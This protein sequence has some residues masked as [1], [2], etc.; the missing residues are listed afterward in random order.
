MTANL[1]ISSLYFNSYNHA[2]ITTYIQELIMRI[3]TLCIIS[4]ILLSGCQKPTESINEQAKQKNV[5][6]NVSQDSCQNLD[7]AM[8]KMNENSTI[9]TLDKI[10]AQLKQC[11]SKVKSPQQLKW[12]NASTKMYHRFLK[13]DTDE[14]SSTAF[15]DYTYSILE[16]KDNNLDQSISTALQGDPE[17]FKKLGKRDQYLLEHQG[18]AYIE[19]QYIGEGI[20]EYRR[21]P[22]Y[23]LDIF[24]RALPKDQ[25]V[26][27]HRMAK[28]NQEP[29]YNDSA[30]AV[31][32]AELVERALF[33]E[34][35]LKQYPNATFKVDA[36]NLFNEYRYLIFFGSDNTPVSDLYF[37][38]EWIDEEALIEIQ[39]L[40]KKQDTT[41]QI[42]AQKFL[43]F[44]QFSTDEHNQVMGTNDSPH[45]LLQQFL[46]L[47]NIWATDNKKDCHRDAICTEVE[48][49]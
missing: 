22:Q 9:E 15:G 10:N 6:K 42:P 3:F 4:S 47:K 25:Q 2:A 8:Q 1:L 21:Q 30:L 35:Y 48:Y 39:K 18:Q 26:F 27:M 44:I 20:F 43:N 5:K 19:F 49:N 13:S 32:W 46:G 36:Q 12:L 33:W 14:L 17:L 11:V 24:A 23:I 45:V 37:K 34:K 28:D 38:D 29:L 40:A 41:L 7:Q 31:S 16:N